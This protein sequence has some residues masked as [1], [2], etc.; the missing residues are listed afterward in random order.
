MPSFKS[1][2]ETW[3]P[4]S[5]RIVAIALIPAPPRP[6]MCM[7]L[8]IDKSS[9]TPE[10][11]DASSLELICAPSSRTTRII[12]QHHSSFSWRDVRRVRQWSLVD[13]VEN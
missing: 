13:D 7:E 12:T 1:L 8:G 11:T 4:I 3:W 9:A 5:T 10:G 6:T 2:P